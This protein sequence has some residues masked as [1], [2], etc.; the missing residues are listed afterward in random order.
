MLTEKEIVV[1]GLRV[2]VATLVKVTTDVPE[3]PLHWIA[4]L[5]FYFIKCLQ[6]IWQNRPWCW[7]SAEIE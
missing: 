3:L 6:K 4:L 1:P 5:M 7:R 2:V